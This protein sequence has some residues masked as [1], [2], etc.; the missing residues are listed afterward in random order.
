MITNSINDADYRN[1]KKTNLN[2]FSFSIQ[3]ESNLYDFQYSK[4]CTRSI[5]HCKTKSHDEV[6]TLLLHAFTAKH[7][8]RYSRTPTMIFF[9]KFSIGE[10]NLDRWT[11]SL[12]RHSDDGNVLFLLRTSNHFYFLFSF[13]FHL[14]SL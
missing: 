6:E 7:D 13:Q 5:V 10:Y 4:H 14:R 1:K 11:Q 9:F 8:E 12:Y 3:F 2:N